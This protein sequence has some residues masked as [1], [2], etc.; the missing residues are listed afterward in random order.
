MKAIQGV[1]YRHVEGRGRRAFLHIAADVQVMMVGAPV[2][3]TVDQPW[4][5]MVREDDGL[6]GSEE[7]IEIAAG[8][9]VRMLLLRLQGHQIDDVDHAYLQPGHMLPKQLY[10]R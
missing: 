7:R 2:S 10:R 9:P 6:L 1:A 3:Q 8:E 5:A 4:I